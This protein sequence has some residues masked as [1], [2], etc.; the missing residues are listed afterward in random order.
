MQ[1]II[2][3]TFESI[4]RCFEHW[5]LRLNVMRCFRKA[6]DTK[7][8]HIFLAIIL[9]SLNSIEMSENHNSH[10]DLLELNRYYHV[11]KMNKRYGEMTHFCDWMKVYFIL[12]SE[13]RMPDTH[14]HT[15]CCLLTWSNSADYSLF[16]TPIGDTDDLINHFSLALISISTDI[17]YHYH[18]NRI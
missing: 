3:C 9:S 12:E 10:A 8:K 18:Y 1:E 16:S 7:G 4:D 2:L 11:A 6:S 5:S 14:T 17:K 15:H 13:Y